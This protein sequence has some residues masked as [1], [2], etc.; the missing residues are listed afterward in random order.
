MQYNHIQKTICRIKEQLDADQGTHAL[1]QKPLSKVSYK[2]SEKT[3]K[4][5]ST[6]QATKVERQYTRR[7]A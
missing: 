2:S 7:R 3:D 1:D 6:R 4:A 5:K